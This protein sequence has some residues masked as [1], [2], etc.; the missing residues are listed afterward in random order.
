M[1]F[2][3]IRIYIILSITGQKRHLEAN[4]RQNIKRILNSS[5][6]HRQTISKP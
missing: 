6:L 2:L 5:I 3:T 1:A 4:H